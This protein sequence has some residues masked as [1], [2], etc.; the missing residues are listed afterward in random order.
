MIINNLPAGR[1]VDNSMMNLKKV[2]IPAAGLATRFLPISKVVP[3]ELLPL[4]DKPMISYVVKE[5]K[6]AGFQ[7]VVFILSENQKDCLAYFKPKPKLEAILEKR[8]QKDALE[9][10]KASEQEFGGVSFSYSLQ[11]L[12]NG[13]GD[14][15]LKAKKQVGK[16][17]FGVLFNDDIFESKTPA[18]LQLKNIF[19][20]SQKPVI[21]LKKVSVDKLSSYGVAKVEKIANSLY[22]IKGLV[23]K[24]Q[25]GV[26]PSDLALCGRYI[27]TPEV[28]GYLEKTAPNKKGEIILAEAIKMMIDDGKIVYGYEIEGDW[29]ECGKIEDW[30]RS[31][32]AM[33]LKHPEYG[34]A[35]KAWVKRLK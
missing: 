29:L 2:I 35:L 32:I 13:D 11:N 17:A 4:A 12:P 8:N 10:L 9:R 7:Q 24:P 16:A 18:I 33:S 31:N 19:E 20:T 30:M 22:K 23:E 21:G 27:L 34:S 26:A 25:A 14:A 1:Q 6:A 5:A 3:K 15:I 28:F